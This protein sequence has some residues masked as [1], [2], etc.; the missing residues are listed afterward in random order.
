MYMMEL[1][2]LVNNWHSRWK[3]FIKILVDELG[4]L[5]QVSYRMKHMMGH[6]FIPGSEVESITLPFTQQVE[7]E[8]ARA[9][10]KSLQR[11]N[12]ALCILHF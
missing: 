12:Y 7:I 4:H 6:L 3:S 11:R 2:N 8:T 5:S 10:H 1:N 9:V